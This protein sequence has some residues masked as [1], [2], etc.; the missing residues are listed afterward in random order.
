MTAP[1]VLHLVATDGATYDLPVQLPPIRSGHATI[2][3]ADVLAVAVQATKQ[4]T[5]SQWINIP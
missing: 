3:I 1:I 5:S 2:R 4:L